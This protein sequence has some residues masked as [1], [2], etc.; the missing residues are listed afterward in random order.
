ME[1]QNYVVNYP[2]AFHTV[3]C[4]VIKIINETFKV[5]LIQKPN[6]VEMGHW[7]FPGGFIDPTD[8][9]AEDAASREVMEETGM[10]IGDI[11]Y[12]GSVKIDDPRYRESPH[13][14]ITSF[15]LGIHVSGDAG[16][17]FDDVAVTKW[18]DLSDV[19]TNKVNQNPTHLPLF[20]MLKNKYALI[21]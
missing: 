3:D 15:F 8:N 7:R 20:K 14:I 16:A 11:E 12:L 19:V 18:F 4:A 10:N 21:K 17:G 2:I 13:K 9:S 1:E 5:L 6:E